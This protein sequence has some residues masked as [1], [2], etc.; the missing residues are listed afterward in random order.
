MFIEA[1]SNTDAGPRAVPAR[2][3]C[4]L[5]R[6]CPTINAPRGLSWLLR[7]GDGSRSDRSLVNI[8]DRPLQ[9]EPHVLPQRQ[10]WRG[11]RFGSHEVEVLV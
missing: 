8:V 2:S 3:V 10:P 4:D 7:A 1:R 6:A 11:F 5:K 9:H